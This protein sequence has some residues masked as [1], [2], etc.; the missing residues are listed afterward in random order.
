MARAPLTICDIQPYLPRA[1]GHLRQRLTGPPGRLLPPNTFFDIG[2][3][4]YA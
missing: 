4:R 2:I 3:S 1:Y